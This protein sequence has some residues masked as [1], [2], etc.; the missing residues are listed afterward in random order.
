M[1]VKKKAVS[2]PALL[3]GM[4]FLAIAGALVWFGFAG[5]HNPQ[6][7][8]KELSRKEKEIK[9]Y[10]GEQETT[11]TP[12]VYAV[13]QKINE[14]LNN[15]LKQLEQMVQKTDLTV[16]EGAV[17]DGLFFREQLFKT[18]KDIHL[19]ASDHETTLPEM[20]GFSDELPDAKRVPLLLRQLLTIQETVTAFIESGAQ[21]LSLV[22][23]LDSVEHKNQD[24]GQVTLVELPVQIAAECD[25][26][27]LLAVLIH[28]RNNSQAIVVRELQVKIKEE[29]ILQVQMVVSGFF[30]ASQQ[31]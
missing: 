22:K 28:L 21:A 27:T 23:P 26:Q 30:I 31:E 19:L 14:K 4:V 25:F 16:P 13:L 9:R 17:T 15:D 20:L 3:A 24:A 2:L 18:G 29:E 10:Q 12:E 7:V 6:E 1:A 11:P 5:K 8:E